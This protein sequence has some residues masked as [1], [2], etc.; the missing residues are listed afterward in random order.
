M[1]CLKWVGSIGGVCRMSKIAKL[2]L[3]ILSGN[4]D[5]NIEFEDLIK[6]LV[7]LKF[8]YRFKGSHP[9][10]WNLSYEEIINIQPLKNKAKAYQV[11]QVREIIL[12]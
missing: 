5:N 7:Y 11:K 3:E 10:F 1:V 4:A 2:F 12:K 8:D 9:I 6:L